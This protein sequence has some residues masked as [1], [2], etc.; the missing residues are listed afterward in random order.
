M[1]LNEDNSPEALLKAGKG[2]ERVTRWEQKK[3]WGAGE[4]MEEIF[5]KIDLCK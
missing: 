1:D 4:L 2:P 5:K 3:K